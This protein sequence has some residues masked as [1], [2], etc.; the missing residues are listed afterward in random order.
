MLRKPCRSQVRQTLRFQCPQR[1]GLGFNSRKRRKTPSRPRPR[2][3]FSVLSIHSILHPTLLLILSLVFLHLIVLAYIFLLSNSSH[4][5]I[6]PTS[7]FD[8][9]KRIELI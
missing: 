2:S 5:P 6:I 7:F 3:Y 8:L 9:L 1:S 4:H